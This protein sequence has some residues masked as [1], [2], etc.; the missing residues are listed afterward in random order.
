V[1]PLLDLIAG[2]STRVP[3]ASQTKMLC[4]Q[5]LEFVSG[6]LDT[7]TP[8]LAFLADYLA[9]ELGGQVLVPTATA[10]EPAPPASILL[11]GPTSVTTQVEH[12]VRNGWPTLK[13]RIRDTQTSPMTTKETLQHVDLIVTSP[14]VDLGEMTES[15]DTGALAR[16]TTGG[17]A[18]QLLEIE[19]WIA[20]LI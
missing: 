3:V 2:V 9:T 11:I 12:A 7:S 4:N 17:P 5:L 16:V 15:A 14:G 10:E 20:T 13:V 19:R 1:G 18:T 8:S 6:R